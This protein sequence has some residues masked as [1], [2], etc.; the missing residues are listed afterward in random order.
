MENIVFDICVKWVNF[1]R[2]V[3]EEYKK[4]MALKYEKRCIPFTKPRLG[5][6]PQAQPRRDK[7][8]PPSKLMLQ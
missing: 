4:T 8:G 7:I 2:Y 1:Q 6:R 5:S 3:L